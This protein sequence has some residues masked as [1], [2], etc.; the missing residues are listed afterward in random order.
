MP[1][2]IEKIQPTPLSIPADSSRFGFSDGLDGAT[3]RE[4]DT[5]LPSVLSSVVASENPCASE[6]AAD[7]TSN[8][9]EGGIQ[10][11]ETPSKH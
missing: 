10:D 3:E 8:D 7:G 11:F 6:S 1:E 9:G 2:L 5:P 4:E